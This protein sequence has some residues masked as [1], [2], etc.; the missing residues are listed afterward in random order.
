MK[1]SCLLFLSFVIAGSA[2]GRAA[3]AD[4]P[5][6]FRSGVD[7]VALNVVVTNAEQ[8]FVTGL[9]AEDFAVYED[10]VQQ[11]LTFFAASEV[12]LDLALLLDTS[13]SMSDKI[14]TVQQAAI[15]FA[16]TLREGDRITV[17]DIKDA[18][19]VLHPL[20]GDIAAARQAILATVPRGGTGLFNGVYLS[21]KELVK[22]RRATSDVRRQ[23]I[24]VL[25][26]GEDTSSLMSYDD[27]MELAKESGIAIY[28]ITLKS[29]WLIRHEAQGGQRRFSQSEFSMK[30]LAQETGAR[31]FFPTDIAELS[32]VYGSIAEELSNQ[33]AIGYTSKNPKR[34]GAFRRVLVRIT[35]RPD[36][37]TRT[38][39]GYLSP[40]PERVTAT[41]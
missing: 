39:S 5:T 15:G 21:I 14:Q 17:V 19:K 7:V 36:V 29:P 16:S 1:R 33:Y 12:P 35:D 30:A 34:D 10:G 22:Q 38:R 37:R 23:A 8:K 26:D 2:S 25:S 11:Q 27:V 41:K 32:G 28:T 3:G 9:A 18:T 40:R 20:D 13:A 6:T 24:V 4:V 31:A